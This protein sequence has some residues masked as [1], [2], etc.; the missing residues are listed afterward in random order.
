MVAGVAAAGA[1]IFFSAGAATPLVAALGTISVAEGVGVMTL[2]GAVG[3][4]IGDA[5]DKP[6]D[7]EEENAT[8]ELETN[9]E[10][11]KTH[12]PNID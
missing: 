1:L 3:G 11:I 2:A 6:R 9:P 4:K 7:I 8:N 10:N 5:V 12:S